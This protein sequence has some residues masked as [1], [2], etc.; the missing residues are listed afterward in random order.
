MH[1]LRIA[2]ICAAM[3]LI[4]WTALAQQESA[5]PPVQTAPALPT[6]PGPTPVPAQSFMTYPLL[7]VP[8]PGTPASPDATPSEPQPPVP[9]PQS[10]SVALD[11]DP[12]KL[13]FDGTEKLGKGEHEIAIKY[14]DEAIE[15]E[16]RDAFRRGRLHDRAYAYLCRGNAWSCKGRS[17]DDDDCYERALNDYSAAL[18]LDS[19]SVGAYVHRGDAYRRLKRFW[20]AID[21]YNEAIRRKAN[22]AAAYCGRGQAHLCL[23]KIYKSAD[24]KD[25]MR[26]ECCRAHKDF[27]RAHDLA[28]APQSG[29]QDQ[30]TP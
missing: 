12:G 6:D 10:P 20:L 2:P 27:K 9:Q 22:C 5:P 7:A 26:I 23:G 29:D 17:D 15:L 1:L 3:T 8:S 30:R 24:Q 16:A 25:L 28:V 14:F 19:A 13:V 21:D 4:P 11:V 18:L